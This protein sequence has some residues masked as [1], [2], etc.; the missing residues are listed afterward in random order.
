LNIEAFPES[1]NV[2]DSYGEALMAGHQYGLAVENY[3]RSVALNPQHD[4]GRKK[5]AQLR[6]LLDSLTVSQF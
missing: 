5:L 3:A 6:L 4:N 2:Y 1:F